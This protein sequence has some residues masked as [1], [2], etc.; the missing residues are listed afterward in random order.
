MPELPEVETIVRQLAPLVAGRRVRSIRVLDPKLTAAAREDLAGLPVTTVTRRGKRIVIAIG[1]SAR[2]AVHLRMTGRLVFVPAGAPGAR[3]ALRATIDLDDGRVEFCDPRRFGTL[4]W[5]DGAAD[6]EPGLD[7]TGPGFTVGALRGLLR[8]ARQPL[9]TWLLR[10]DRLA[11]LGN[12][13]ASEILHR[14]RLSPFRAGGTLSVEETRRLHDATRAVLEDAIRNC[15]TTFSDFKDAHGV[16]G[17]YQQFLRVYDRAG[18]PCPACGTPIRRQVQQQ[19]STYWCPDCVRRRPRQRP[20]Q[21]EKVGTR[22]DL[23]KLL[24]RS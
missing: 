3:R 19:R 20:P 10:Q 12:I 23:K 17:Q 2:L 5:I 13:Y 6:A 8:G 24:G 1:A 15:G 14:A 4:E 7:P 22:S 11:G 21:K 16:T 9:K 18:Q